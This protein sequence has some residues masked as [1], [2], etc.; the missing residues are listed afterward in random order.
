M[1]RPLNWL[2][3]PIPILKLCQTA[4]LL[5]ATCLFLFTFIRVRRVG[6]N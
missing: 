4:S 6:I 3:T 2:L 5:L 1:T